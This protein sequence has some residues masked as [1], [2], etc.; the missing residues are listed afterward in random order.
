MNLRKDHY[1]FVVDRSSIGIHKQQ[2]SYG[3]REPA[4]KAGPQTTRL[5]RAGY[6]TRSIVE[7]S[8]VGRGERRS[9]DLLATARRR[10]KE[11]CS[12]YVAPRVFFFIILF[13]TVD[14]TSSSQRKQR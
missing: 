14:I 7:L 12:T 10:F 3:Q 5:K 4:R 8:I 2:H 13:Y 6:L 1:C 11:R 9:S